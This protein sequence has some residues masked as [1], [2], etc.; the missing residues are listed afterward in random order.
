[1]LCFYMDVF[2]N[3]AIYPPWGLNGTSFPSE[4]FILLD[5]NQL[6]YHKGVAVSRI[7]P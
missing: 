7:K 4:Y 5:S 2:L 1:M 6:Q 3:T